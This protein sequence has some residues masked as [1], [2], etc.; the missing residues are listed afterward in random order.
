MKI[1]PTSLAELF[2]HGGKPHPG[3]PA[4]VF[5]EKMVWEGNEPQDLLELKKL[6]PV[7]NPDYRFRANMVRDYNAWSLFMQGAFFLYGPSQCGKTEFV[8]E[9]CSRLNVPLFQ[10]TVNS[11][12]TLAE[13][14]G[15]YVLAE[16]GETMFRYGPAALA[17]KYGAM[18]LLDE[19]GR[20][21]PGVIVGLNGLMDK[22][23]FTIT[24]NGETIIPSPDFKLMLT[25]NTNLCGDAGGNFNTAMIH[26]KSVLERIGMAVKVDYPEEEEREILRDFAADILPENLLKYWF[27]QEKLKVTVDKVQ[28]EGT[29]VSLDDFI[30]GILQVRDL[31]RK[32][33]ID[34]GNK[35]PNA[36]ERTM[37]V[38]TLK[39][40]VSYCLAFHSYADQN[41][42]ALHYSLDRALANLCTDSTK[43]AIHG[44]VTAVFGV[45]E[46]IV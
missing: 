33:S 4:T 28:K 34:G 29:E 9:L 27:D 26:D 2:G 22:R 19:F 44:M 40:W 37:S 21:S 38:P 14:F 3:L 5:L 32:Q 13:M 46:K 17:A 10:M 7:S 30:S 42:S 12:T 15:H 1:V 6:I 41:V 39:R 11:E 16:N 35:D 24:G 31:V 45:K 25:D 18:L 23:A 43:I 36:L 8:R 20:G